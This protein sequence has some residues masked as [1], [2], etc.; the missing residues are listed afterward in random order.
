M[1][2]HFLFVTARQGPDDFYP[3]Y[4]CVTTFQGAGMT[5]WAEAGTV[6]Q[7]F[8]YLMIPIFGMTQFRADVTAEHFSQA[9]LQTT[10][11]WWEILHMTSLNEGMKRLNS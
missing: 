5:L 2:S 7:T 11:F 6:L 3:A 10:S 1:A 8:E 9:S 4:T